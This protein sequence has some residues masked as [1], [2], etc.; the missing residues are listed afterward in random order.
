[1]QIAGMLLITNKVMD[2]SVTCTAM[3]SALSVRRRGSGCLLFE[4]TPP[5]HD[6]RR[7]ADLSCT[8]STGLGTLC[9]DKQVDEVGTMTAHHAVK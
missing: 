7:F 3:R 6:W 8:L 9:G 5:G 4:H 2:C 1:M